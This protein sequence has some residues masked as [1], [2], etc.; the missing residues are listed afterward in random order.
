MDISIKY[1]GKQEQNFGDTITKAGQCVIRCQMCTKCASQMGT[2]AMGPDGTSVT[3]SWG[4]TS[5]TTPPGLCRWATCRAST[6]AARSLAWPGIYDPST[7]HK[8]QG[9]K[10]LQGLQVTA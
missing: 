6:R 3:P 8:A 10:G 7:A 5:V 1:S 4:P 2:T 9:P